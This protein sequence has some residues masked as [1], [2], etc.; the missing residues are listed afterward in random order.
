MN[1]IYKKENFMYHY[2]EDKDF[3]KQMKRLCSDII[4]QLV[5]RINNDAMMTVKARLVGSGAKNLITQNANEPID[6]DY[7]LCVVEVSGIS[8]NDSRT[9]KE[10]IRKHFNKILQNNGLNDCQDSTSVLSTKKIYFKKGNKTDFNID[11]AI[12]R[13]NRCVWERLIHQKTGC[14][15]FDQWL[16]NEAPNSR[17]LDNKVDDIKHRNQWQE[18]RKLY[19][20]KKNIYLKRNDYNH[21]SFTVY[22]ETINEIHSKLYIESLFYF[23][24]HRMTLW[25]YGAMSVSMCMYAAIC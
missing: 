3:L 2:I 9:I 21:L 20:E 24:F 22:I 17:N 13:N 7:N 16:W 12:V 8:F 19:L 4:N 25:Q 18:V 5:Q 15:D 10:H 14:I 11:L 23:G 6:L 1:N